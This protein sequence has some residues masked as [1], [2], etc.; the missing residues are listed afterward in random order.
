MKN[1]PIKKLLHRPIAVMMM[2]ITVCLI[3]AVPDAVAQMN[4]GEK[5]FGP[6]AGY[7][8]KNESVV[9]GVQFQYAFSG[10]FRIA[11]DMGYVFRNQNLD[12]FVL[13][14]NALFPFAFSGERV[15]LYPLAGVAFRSWNPHNVNYREESVF[16]DSDNATDITTRKSKLGINAG[17]GFEMRLTPA[18]KLAVEAG[19]TFVK[20]FGCTRIIASLAYVF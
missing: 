7:A 10:H 13:D 17:A 11:P 15:A 18:M 12:A 20:D 19:Y 5:A 6:F 8:S 4:K 1:I 9:A 2:T 3:M 14:V 16:G